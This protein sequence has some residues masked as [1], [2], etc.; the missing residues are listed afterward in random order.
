[1]GRPAPSTEVHHLHAEF[2]GVVVLLKVNHL[3]SRLE[4]PHLGASAVMKGP[5]WDQFLD[6]EG[7]TKGGA[8]VPSSPAVEEA[9]GGADACV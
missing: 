4:L 5:P 1:V 8:T 3:P 7:G 9:K 6:T 2:D